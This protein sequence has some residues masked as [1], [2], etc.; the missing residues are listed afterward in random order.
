MQK[1]AIAPV[2]VLMTVNDNETHAIWDEFIGQ[3]NAPVQ[4]T[5]G[6]V[7]YCE[8]GVHG[9]NQIVHT[10]C[11]M[12]AGAVGASQQR[13][14]D[15]IEHWKPKAVI[16][17]GIAF[18]L[19]ETKQKVGDVLVAKQIQDYEL[20]RLNSDGTLTPR[21]DKPGCSQSL[22]NRL[23][24][25]DL[26]RQRSSS[27]RSWPK[28]RYGL[29]LSGQKL[30]DNLDYR[31]SLKKLFAL[32]IG[33]EMEGSGL[34]ASAH[35][36]KVDWIVVK[37]ICD[38]GHDKNQGMKDEW[39]K[40]AAQNAA[41]VLKAALEVDGL[42]GAKGTNLVSKPA[43]E[44][45]PAQAYIATQVVK[46]VVASAKMSSSPLAVAQA[47]IDTASTRAQLAR[48][49]EAS[50]RLP[51]S[52]ALTSYRR[53]LEAVELTTFY[54]HLA[55]GVKAVLGLHS[56]PT[57]SELLNELAALSNIDQLIAIVDQLRSAIDDMAETGDDAVTCCDAG[58]AF[59]CAWVQRLSVQQPDSNFKSMPRMQG[60]PG[61]SEQ[62]AD[63]AG[64]R[65]AGFFA[66]AAFGQR[67]EFVDTHNG[68]APR[69]GRRLFVSENGECDEV[70]AHW[71]LHKAFS[72]QNEG[73]AEQVAKSGAFNQQA[74]AV[75]RTNLRTMRD[76]YVKDDVVV[77]VMSA[78]HI[79]LESARD[80][81]QSYS[82]EGLVVV[83]EVQ[84]AFAWPFDQIS[85]VDLYANIETLFSRIA[86]VK[87]GAGSKSSNPH[88]KEQ[89]MTNPAPFNQTNY[90]APVQNNTAS[91]SN[92]VVSAVWNLDQSQKNQ[93]QNLGNTLIQVAAQST[94]P[95]EKMLL[96]DLGNQLQAQAQLSAPD[97]SAI[98]KI[99][100][101]L[102]A[103]AEPV[104][105]VQSIKDAL[106]AG[107]AVLGPF[108]A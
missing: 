3:G 46:R 54:H 38:W 60:N 96:T 25:T 61:D 90:Y 81:A 79:S 80:V 57:P 11:E 17:V 40:L 106:V 104:N 93:L 47:V 88:P 94:Q 48:Q 103:L 31:E 101:T 78:K 1:N 32:A 65:L 13:A 105:A 72:P 74:E 84:S 63:M 62:L 56:L 44:S 5:K 55:T 97:K 41:Q 2:I 34:Y 45:A 14:S 58:V 73:I 4:T 64:L 26:S 107:V 70:Q 77:A 59:F 75:L 108:L 83:H 68:A 29:V 89:P 52:K 66:A 12:G 87:T 95:A 67:L 18:G 30:V 49:V 19:D 33:G 37:A 21:S 8:L 7:T 22:V 35:A 92:S 10:V 76:K 99:W 24:Q 27:G 28:V 102:K 16:A 82:T 15:A 43:L 69:Y 71:A 50:A 86:L 9:G 53:S 100:T 20:G 51:L 39:Q 85:E 23:T 36:K 98:T 91:G 6:A 42:Y